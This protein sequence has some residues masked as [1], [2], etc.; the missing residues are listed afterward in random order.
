MERL[1]H[2]YYER[3]V[4]L[5]RKTLGAQSRGVSA[6]D[7]AQSAFKSFYFRAQDDKFPRLN[8]RDDLWKILITITLRKAWRKR[9]REAKRGLPGD[10]EIIA[11]ELAGD[12]PTPATAAAVTDE[13]RRL[14]RLLDDPVLSAIAL[15]KMEGHTNRE[16][17]DV[18]EISVATV[19]RKL[20]LTRLCVV[21]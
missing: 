1:W 9:D 14:F 10:P 13:F 20:Q 5:A 3:L 16:I 19:E 15:M 21:R 11:Q 12:G 7:I 17:A 8:D 4:S 6:E 2:R 18:M